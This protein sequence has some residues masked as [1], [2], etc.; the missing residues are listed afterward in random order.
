MKN[1]LAW[2]S[3]KFVS[4]I[5]LGCSRIGSFSN[6]LSHSDIQRLLGAALEAGVT[7]FDTSDVYGQGDSERELGRCLAGHR[8]AQAIVVTKGG[9]LFSNKMR[10]LRPFKPLLKPLLS[11]GGRKVVT[12][13]RSDEISEDFS[14][15]HITRAVEGSLKRLR[16]D[17]LDGFLLHSPKSAALQPEL[18]DTLRRLRDAGKIDRY[19]VSCD[20]IDVLQA[21]LKSP[22]TALLELPF[23]VLESIE[24]TPIAEEIVRRNILVL[25]REVLR[26]QPG[27][28]VRKAISKA[29]SMP[30]V[31]TVIVGTTNVDHLRE[32]ISA[33]A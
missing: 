17:R 27:I 28:E 29:A 11:R 30:C 16:T 8:R 15:A 25:A 18:W 10:L 4:P 31:S 21:S 6:S 5:G 14:P 33:I 12:E 2:G 3:N 7:I 22:D 23:D 9:K 1:T 24:G 32:S 20:T 26:F 13:R 19:G